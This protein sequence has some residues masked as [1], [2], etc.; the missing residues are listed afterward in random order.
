MQTGGRREG[1]GILRVLSVD[2]ALRLGI[3]RIVGAD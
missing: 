2:N 3:W 1:G